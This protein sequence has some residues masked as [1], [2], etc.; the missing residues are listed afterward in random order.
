VPTF[1]RCQGCP[2]RLARMDYIVSRDKNFKPLSPEKRE[3]A[4]IEAMKILGTYSPKLTPQE[5]EVLAEEAKIS[6][7][8]FRQDTHRRRGK[9]IPFPLEDIYYSTDD[10]Q[11]ADGVYDYDDPEFLERT[12]GKA[13]GAINDY[14]RYFYKPGLYCNEAQL[15]IATEIAL[16]IRAVYSDLQKIPLAEKPNDPTD[17]DFIRLGQWF[18]DAYITITKDTATN[19]E[20]DTK[21]KEQNTEIYTAIDCA[22]RS[23]TIGGKSYSIT[24]ET[25]WEFL[26]LL[27]T[28]QKQDKLTPRL[29]GAI[30]HKNA[31][32]MLRRK[33]TTEGL[34]RIIDF[35]DGGYKL[36]PSVSVRYAGQAAI[37][38][39]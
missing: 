28:N 39:T 6:S 22:K 1:H 4:R 5:L 33:L 38:K 18:L 37:R 8:I 3:M 34:S 16:D 17:E 29:D 27:I 26:R 24:S 36:K 14:R 35:L 9:R 10:T 20:L 11:P 32:D 13:Y 25:S 19:S 15:R 21:E 12:S 7:A 2:E 31:V 23:I 30:D